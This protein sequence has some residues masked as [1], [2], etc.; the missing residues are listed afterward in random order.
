MRMAL[1]SL[2]AGIVIACVSCIAAPARA[3]DAQ[4]GCDPQREDCGCA[5]DWG[6]FALFYT[7][8]GS[9]LAIGGTATHVS[10][11]AS[12]RDDAGVVTSYRTEHFSTLRGLAGHV[13]LSFAIGGGTAGTET[14]L[15]GSV[16]FGMRLAMT[17]TSGPFLRAGPSG[18][19]VGHRRLSLSLIDPLQARVGY[20][21]LD[22][23]A[24]VEWGL[25]FGRSWA[26]RLAAAGLSRELG[27]AWSL[28]AYFVA[29]MSDFRIHGSLLQLVTTSAVPAAEVWLGQ[30]GLCGY[31]RPFALCFELLDARGDGSTRAGARRAI[32]T[33]YAGLA[34]GLTP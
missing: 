2:R 31:P 30:L 7:A 33:R 19:L 21:S 24:L 4:A 18:L 25:L 32:R 22:G 14:D 16:D 26:G 3:D 5:H 34:L 20:Q 9:V 12:E 11:G 29:R 28:G 6:C 8:K 17:D 27:N 1:P 13:Q 15:R 10:G 23:D